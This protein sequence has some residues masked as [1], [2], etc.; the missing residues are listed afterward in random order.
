MGLQK[1]QVKFWSSPYL[2]CIQTAAGIANSMVNVPH[3]SEIVISEVLGEFQMAG[4]CNDTARVHDLIVNQ[5][6][7]QQLLAE[8]V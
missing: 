1:D 7:K 6:E 2:R 3:T 5:K 8:D 4:Y